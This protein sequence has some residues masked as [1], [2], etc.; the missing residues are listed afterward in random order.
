MGGEKSPRFPREV[1]T[2]CTVRCRGANASSC[3]GPATVGPAATVSRSASPRHG[4]P[5]SPPPDASAR[6]DPLIDRGQ[7]AWRGSGVNDAGG[8]EEHQLTFL[9][10]VRAVF[11]LSRDHEELAGGSAP[12]VW[13]INNGKSVLAST[14]VDHRS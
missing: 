8:L 14:V 10:R 1:W 3:R 4:A 2:G 5:S 7:L 13:M 9:G 6:S 12:A 11:G